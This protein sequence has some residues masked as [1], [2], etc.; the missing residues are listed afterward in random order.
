MW[1]FAQPTTARPSASSPPPF[2]IPLRIIFVSSQSIAL[3]LGCTGLVRRWSPH[4][5]P[6]CPLSPPIWYSKFLS[7]HLLTSWPANPSFLQSQIRNLKFVISFPS[8]L[9][10]FRTPASHLPTFSMFRLE[11]CYLSFLIPFPRAG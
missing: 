2:L 1:P 6:S 10:P 5:W 7:G 9:A 11:T 3:A 8:C 4:R